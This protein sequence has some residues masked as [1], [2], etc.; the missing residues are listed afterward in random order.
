MNRKL[1]PLGV[2]L[3]GL[4][5]FG[6]FL[7]SAYSEMEEVKLVGVCDIEKGRTESL[8]SKHS[9]K[10][11]EEFSGLLEDPEIEIVVI[12]T[13]PLLHGPM[14][15]QASRAGK[16]L[17]VEKPLAITFQEAKLAVQAAQENKVLLTVDY[18]LRH[19]PLH[20]LA[21]RILAGRFFGDLRFFSLVN[22]ATNDGLGPHHWFWD[23]TKSGGILVEHGVHFF[24]LAN[25]LAGQSP[26]LVQ[27]LALRSPDGRVDRMGAVVLYGDKLWATFYHS[28]DRPRCIEKTTIFLGLT[29]G[30]VVLDGWIPVKLTF[31]GLV[32]TE[33]VQAFQDLVSGPFVV[34]GR[35]GARVEVHGEVQAPDRQGEYKRA[36]QA[37]MRDL[38]WAIREERGPLITPEDALSS[39]EVALKATATAGL[40]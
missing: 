15:V 22:L 34:G 13:P 29:N 30:E 37:V 9:I 11:Y 36:V 21:Q 16:H 31:H 40:G 27:G 2:G 35:H 32:Q 17:V 10:V 26:T 25:K 19:H 12:S 24:D 4:G 6:E 7:L 38:I 3:V 39:L 8:A 33:E 20:Q 14:A 1:D 18:V 5:R 28:F 23:V